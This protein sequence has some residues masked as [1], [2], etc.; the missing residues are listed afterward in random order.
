MAK[1][2][3]TPGAGEN[4]FEILSRVG[5]AADTRTLMHHLVSK[6]LD[7]LNPT[8]GVSNSYLV[9]PVDDLDMSVQ[10]A[11]VLAEDIRKYFM[12]P[13]V[14]ILVAAK[15]DQLRMAVEQSYVERFRDYRRELQKPT[16]EEIEAMSNLYL[17]KL[18]PLGRRL[19]M[20]DFSWVEISKTTHLEWGGEAK[21]NLEEF[22]LKIV[23]EKTKLYFRPQKDKIHPIVPRT[24]REIHNFLKWMEN[25]PEA[26]GL[27]QFKQYLFSEWIPR[28]F[29]RQEE[30]ILQK[31]HEASVEDKNWIIVQ[32][33]S[34]WLRINLD[35]LSTNEEG[36]DYQGFEQH[37]RWLER[38]FKSEWQEILKIAD[39]T[40]PK[41][42]VSIGD[43][44]YLLNIVEK[45]TGE[46]QGSQLKFAIKT[47]ISIEL[48]ESFESMFREGQLSKDSEDRLER[49]INGSSTHPLQLGMFSPTNFKT[50]HTNSSLKNTRQTLRMT[51]GGEVGDGN[52][53]A[54][55]PIRLS[56]ICDEL[57]KANNLPVDP[58]PVF[59]LI[60]LVLYFGKI[61]DSL[62]GRRA[63]TKWY[64]MLGS[65][66][67]EGPNASY[68]SFDF[69]AFLFWAFLP[70]KSIDRVSRKQNPARD[71]DQDTSLFPNDQEKDFAEKAI[72]NH[73]EF[74]SIILQ[75]EIIEAIQEWMQ[76]R[77]IADQKNQ[78]FKNQYLPSFFLGWVFRHFYYACI[79]ILPTGTSVPFY[80]NIFSTHV[81]EPIIS[82]NDLTELALNNRNIREL[83]L[84]L[85]EHC[86]SS[87]YDLSKIA[88]ARQNGRF[89]DWLDILRNWAP[90]SLIN[91]SISA[92]KQF[93]KEIESKSFDESF[94]SNDDIIKHLESQRSKILASQKAET[95]EKNYP[96]I[97]NGVF[98]ELKRFEA[99][100]GDEI[101]WE[102]LDS[103]MQS[104]SSLISDANGR[105]EIEILLLST[106][107]EMILILK[108]DDE[109]M[110]LN[111]GDLGGATE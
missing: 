91:I 51:I 111:D 97:I 94:P 40:K 14:I 74:W 44:R 102:E 62:T 90:K 16:Q 108:Q 21:G 13:N 76:D 49:L 106:I 73:K 19:A 6:L 9:I 70:T 37:Q 3:G 81:T 110:D 78:K 63:L 15:V 57:A 52:N 50:L 20:P 48:L 26:N 60:S 61:Q 67:D 46:K 25:N 88:F 23:K 87:P 18:I 45:L 101:D 35:V 12:I 22:I 72:V 17:E 75:L 104:L 29:Q 58:N 89:F 100:L 95:K 28:N 96:T 93:E 30:Q 34:Y 53:K 54:L 85:N 47:V 79:E 66:F 71:L 1:P 109:D 77:F 55:A 105:S 98:K 80:H 36:F 31:I 92:L 86:G 33:L 5:K 2:F 56:K 64:N 24:L 4:S 84:V 59:W 107:D 39:R 10:H 103:K 99:K 8:I 38:T 69:W 42:Q 41:Y 11:Y 27:L 7:F 43:V 68:L 32:S 65:L 82:D 83:R